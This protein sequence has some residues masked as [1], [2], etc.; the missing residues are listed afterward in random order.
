MF[1][2]ERQNKICKIIDKNGAVTTSGLVKKFDVSVETVRRDLL[3]LEKR[4]R[5][6]R[7][8][9]GAIKIGEMREFHNRVK[10]DEENSAEKRELGAIAANLVSPG[11]TIAV[12]FGSTAIGFAEGIKDIPDLTVITHSVDVFDVLKSSKNTRVIL[13]GG[14]FFP[15]EKTFG[16]HMVLWAYQKFHVNKSF[17]FPSAIS[18]SCGLGDFL[19]EYHAIQ[20]V[21]TEICDR[22]FILADNSKYEKKALYKLDDMKTDYV[23]VSDPYLP[24][25]LKRLYIENGIKI[26]TTKEDIKNYDF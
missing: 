5:L 22:V 10:R 23:Y 3:E 24:E 21:L 6:K 1:A 13:T 14:E 2:N 9:G 12:D 8:H 20:K 4:G 25:S 17:V 7:V 18:L 19:S 15:E 16:G 26:I 11:D